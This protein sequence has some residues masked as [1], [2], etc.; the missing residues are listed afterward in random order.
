MSFDPSGGATVQTPCGET[1]LNIAMDTDGDALEF[2]TVGPMASSCSEEE[3]SAD[4]ALFNAL[5]RVESWQVDDD[6]HIRF[7]GPEKIEATRVPDPD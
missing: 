3:R 1:N 4:A 7:V 5:E 6:D 2:A